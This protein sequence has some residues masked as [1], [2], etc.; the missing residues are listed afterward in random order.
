VLLTR[1]E[2]FSLIKILGF[3][4]CTSSLE[5]V[6]G[7]LIVIFSQVIIQP[8]VGLK[9]TRMLKF[10][11]DFSHGHI[12][13]YFAVIVGIMYL[14]KTLVAA[15][16]IFYQNFSIQK[17]N[18]NFKKKL[19]HGYAK[20][21]YGIYLTR[22]SSLGIQVVSGDSELMFS[23][24]LISIVSILSESIVCLCLIGMVVYINPT[25]ALAIFGILVLLGICITKGVLPKFYQFGQKLQEAATYS[26][27][28]LFQFFHAFKE[29]VLLGKQAAFINAYQFHF[30]KQ[31]HV[32]AMQSAI[33]LLPRI[34]IELTF[35]GLF[36]ITIAF[37]CLKHERPEQMLG[38]LGGYLY[39]GFRLMPALNRVI[40]QLNLFKSSI[41]SIE[42]VYHEYTVVPNQQN[43]VEVPNFT[44]EHIISLQNVSFRYLNT[45]KDIL[46]GITFEIKKGECIG[47]IGETGSG[48]STLVDLILGLL[49]PYQGTILIDKKYPVNSHQWHQ[50]VGY[51]PQNIYL[52][53]DTIQA[54]IAFGDNVIDEARLN[55]VIDAAQLRKFIEQLAEGAKTIVGERGLRLSGGERQR[56]AIARAL[57]RNPDIIIFDEATS[58]LDNETAAK[59]MD[60][61]YSISQHRTVIMIA[62][63]LVSLKNCNRI[64]VLEQGKIKNIMTYEALHSETNKSSQNINKA[65]GLT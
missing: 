57:Y 64:I 43:Y 54:N 13:F 26:G 65:K 36:L 4:L 45:K 50:I 16:E 23:T 62:H 33:S 46:S 6:T 38:I 52:T 17:M 47:I 7:S 37:L 63:R 35:V 49:K 25:L 27:Q 3:A 20:T 34:I 59:L 55:T 30:S 29:I 10:G 8:E 19:L 60:T 22:N 2:K 31:S 42:R 53:D 51:V 1:D 9:Y 15:M 12:I 5:V 41:P 48:K 44:F 21:D 24:G 56:I 39:T 32:R 11:N 58:A 14:L 61:I 28:N 18:C 40:S